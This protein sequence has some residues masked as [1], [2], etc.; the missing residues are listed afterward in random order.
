MVGLGIVAA[1]LGYCLAYHGFDRITGGNDGFVSLIWPG[2]YTVTA[3]D[4][5]G[6]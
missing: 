5:S 6:K 1:W 4:G 3:R 2:R